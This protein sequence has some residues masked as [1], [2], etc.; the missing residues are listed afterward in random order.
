MSALFLIAGIHSTANLKTYEKAKN[1]FKPANTQSSSEES[2][3]EKR[4]TCI[5]ICYVSFSLSSTW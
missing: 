3:K 2:F 4:K 1:F 5:G